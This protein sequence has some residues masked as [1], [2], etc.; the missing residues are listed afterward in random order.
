MFARGG[1][2]KLKQMNIGG[3]PGAESEAAV[4]ELEAAREGLR[5]GLAFWAAQN[6]KQK[7]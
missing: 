3:S 4:A 2:P 7:K 5:V 6:A 1:A